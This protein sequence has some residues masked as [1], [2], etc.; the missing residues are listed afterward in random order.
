MKKKLAVFLA[1]FGFIGYLPA[2]PGTWASAA[3]AL[4]AFDLGDRPLI[5]GVAFGACCALGL[6]SA[7]IAAAVFGKSDPGPVVI[8]E[9]CG[10]LLVFLFVPAAPAA[11][12]LGFV[13][14]RI[15]DI[16]KPL[17]IRRLERLPPP[18][19]IMLDDLAAGLLVGSVLWLARWRG[20]L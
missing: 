17:G 4:L 12:V 11:L 20:M 19:G 18:W 1:T 2:A 7:R 9:V 6:W 5:L 13:G 3:A 8:D 10:M 14:F 15:A 16:L